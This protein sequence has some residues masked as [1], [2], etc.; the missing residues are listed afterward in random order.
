MLFGALPRCP[1]EQPGAPPH[2][3][4]FDRGAGKY[5]CTG[6]TQWSSRCS[7]ETDQ[8][9][10]TKAWVIPAEFD[11]EDV[12]FLASW[13]FKPRQ[14]LLGLPPSQ[15]ATAAAVAANMSQQNV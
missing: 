4:A 6:S 13:R 14:K 12:P 3:L 15:R 2:F 9:V 8:V 10:E 1:R 11:L 5:V 7:Y